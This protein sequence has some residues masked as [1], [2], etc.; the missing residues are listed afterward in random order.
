MM[1]S[2]DLN[3]CRECGHWDHPRADDEDGDLWGCAVVWMGERC[4]CGADPLA[5]TISPDAA[6]PAEDGG[7]VEAEIVRLGWITHQ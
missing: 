2:R 5:V 6:G 1:D 7:A 4:G 3:A